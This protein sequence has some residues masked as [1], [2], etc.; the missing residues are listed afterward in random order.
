M[1]VVVI[2]PTYNER[3]NII[4]LLDQL[5]TVF[6]GLKRHTI[7]YLVVDDTSPDGTGD[8]VAEYQKTHKNV[9]SISGKKEGLGKRFCAA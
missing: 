5:E 7:S 6:R 2:I 9:F 1:K 3:E 4:V 8:V